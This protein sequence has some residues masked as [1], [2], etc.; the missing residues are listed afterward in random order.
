MDLQIIFTAALVIL[1]VVLLIM[2]IS[3]LYNEM[4]E[5]LSDNVTNAVIDSAEAIVKQLGT[6]Q[7]SMTDK[8][9]TLRN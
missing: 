4:K 7:D 5:F 6:L 3:M 8:M 2:I 9:N 1:L